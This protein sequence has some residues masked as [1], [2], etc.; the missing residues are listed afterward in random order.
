M[1]QFDRPQV[2]QLASPGD[3]F[4]QFGLFF[5]SGATGRGRTCLA[6]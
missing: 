4:L 5:E 2:D 6:K 3:E 1:V